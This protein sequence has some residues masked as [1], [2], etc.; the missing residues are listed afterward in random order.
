M[1][2]SK[3]SSNII[4]LY[5]LTIAKILFPLLTFPYLTRVLSVDVYG[6]V[7]YVR[8][9]IIYMQI[10][11][12]FGFSLS[13]VKDIVRIRNDN[14][15]V[16]EITGDVIIAKLLLCVIGMLILLVLCASIP[17]LSNNLLYT[18]LSY[19]VVI[20]SVFLLDYL[21][22]GIEEMQL[23]SLSFIIMKG[24]STLL[25]FVFV[26]GDADI[27]WI[28]VL[29]IISSFF[30]LFFVYVQLK[31]LHIKIIFRNI[32]YAWRS[33]KESFI[34]FISN[35]ATTA[36]GGLNT[37]LIGIYIPDVKEIAYW[38]VAMTLISGAQALYNPITGGVYPQMVKNPSMRII[39]RLLLVFMP[40]VIMGC[41]FTWVFAGDIVR[42]INGP[43]YDEAAEVLRYLVPVL[44]F[45]FPG[46]LIGWPALGAIDKAA[47]VTKTTIFTCIFQLVGLTL[48]IL[49]NQFTLIMISILRDMTEAVLLGTRFGYLVKYRKYFVK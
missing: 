21:F 31:K 35:M 47:D 49:Y 39:R 27:L 37:M 17:I 33:L 32:I 41:L 1:S 3:I 20:L 8:A 22:R 38:S 14:K 48:L 16:G 29:D 46:M 36:F 25:T 43:N 45:S 24:A 42:I 26:K 44:F 4:Y 15:K 18:F 7:S 12:D 23:V 5:F 9:T 13:A 6:M 40:C 2:H 34:Y 19:V 28:P 10:L 11:V 30:A